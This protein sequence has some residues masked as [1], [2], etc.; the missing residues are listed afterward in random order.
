MLLIT[1]DEMQNLR[2]SSNVSDLMSFGT[3]DCTNLCDIR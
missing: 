1:V 2:V 3:T